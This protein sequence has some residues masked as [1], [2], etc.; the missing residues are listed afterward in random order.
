MIRYVCVTGLIEKNKD[1]P[2]MNVRERG[3]MRIP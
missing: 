1:R 2:S 3:A